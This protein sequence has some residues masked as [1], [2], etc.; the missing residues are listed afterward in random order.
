M[1]R[2]TD[3]DDLIGDFN[4]S[5]TGESLTE[6]ELF[7][8]YEMGITNPIGDKTGN[9]T[10]DKVTGGDPVDMITGALEWNYTDLSI[11]GDKQ[12]VFNRFVQ[13]APAESRHCR[14]GKWME[15]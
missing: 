2:I 14:A 9:Y 4:E 10:V 13:F 12:M 1:C 6:E 7:Q 8:L 5:G 3:R 11:E 15:S